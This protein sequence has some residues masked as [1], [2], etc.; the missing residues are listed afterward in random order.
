LK[1]R[2]A[3]LAAVA[4]FAIACIGANAATVAVPKLSS[5]PQASEKAFIGAM[6]ADLMKRFPTAASAEAAGYFR[7]T[8]EDSTGAISYA[9][10]QWT[11]DATHPSQLWYDVNGN[12][13]GADFSQPAAATAPTIWGILPARW[14]HFAHPHVHYVYTENGATVYGHATSY[15]KFIAAGGN[16]TTPTGDTFVKLGLVTDPAQ[17]THAFVFPAIW[18]LIVWVK[19]NPNG[20]FANKNPNVTPSANAA[21]SDD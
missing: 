17:V 12:L 8:N 10:L 1:H 21:K 15:T 14:D 2:I 9:N 11:S 18:D 6:Q 4:A 5:Q 7:Y 13:L 19:A 20:A 16:A 3:A